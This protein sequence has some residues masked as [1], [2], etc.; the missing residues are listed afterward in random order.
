MV[1]LANIGPCASRGGWEESAANCLRVPARR[2]RKHTALSRVF[3]EIS[4]HDWVGNRDE[5]R[6]TLYHRGH[7]R[8]EVTDLR[9]GEGDQQGRSPRS[10]PPLQLAI[11]VDQAPA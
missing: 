1:N 6:R 11:A 10:T 4:E 9:P 5:L 3:Q 8:G 2:R 7:Q